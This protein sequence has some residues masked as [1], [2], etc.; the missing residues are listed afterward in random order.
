[1]GR[2]SAR[3]GEPTVRRNVET[4]APK[5]RKEWAMSPELVGELSQP[6]PHLVQR[7]PGSVLIWG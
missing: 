6:L 3:V 7:N 2:Q 5:R 4:R 1:M